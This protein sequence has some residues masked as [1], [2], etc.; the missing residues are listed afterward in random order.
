[1]R[2]G[3]RRHRQAHHTDWVVTALEDSRNKQRRS[4]VGRWSVPRMRTRRRRQALP[5]GLHDT[6]SWPR[7]LL[8]TL[9]Q[10]RRGS[11]REARSGGDGATADGGEGLGVTG[12]S[13]RV[14]DDGRTVPSR[15]RRCPG[16]AV[17]PGADRLDERIGDERGEAKNP[18][19]TLGEVTWGRDCCE[20]G[21]RPSAPTRV[22]WRW[23]VW[24]GGS[25]VSDGVQRG[26]R[27]DRRT[28]VRGSRDGRGR[29]GAGE[30]ARS[31]RR[32]GRIRV[33]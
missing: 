20:M 7:G 13:S 17:P 6:V 2:V 10:H 26:R 22:R 31:G 30:G 8:G 12:V 19:G 28:A 16:P 18:G 15:I 5:T 27:W 21:G 9:R 14:S 4:G 33:S 25:Q 29:G 23:L 11:G 3:R 1:M 24:E 32:W